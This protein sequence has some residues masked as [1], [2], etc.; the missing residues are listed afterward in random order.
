MSRII[1]HMA[2]PFA[3]LA[4]A[5]SL[6]GLSGKSDEHK[7]R[8]Q[9]IP[10]KPA[11]IWDGVKGYPQG[12]WQGASQA[13][14]PEFVQTML[15]DGLSKKPESFYVSYWE[16]DLKPVEGGTNCPAWPTDASFEAFLVLL[17]LEVVE[18]VLGGK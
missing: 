15:G 17:G 5:N 18:T 10:G 14:T 13:L 6:A 11:A 4:V 16:D 2:C 8:L 9:S 1:V 3:R 7:I 12:R